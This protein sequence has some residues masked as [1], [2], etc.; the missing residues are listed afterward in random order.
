MAKR[1]LFR[2]ETV[3]KVRKQR[4]DACKRA[5]AERLRRISA[6][7]AEIGSLRTQINT[8]IGAFR[9]AHA[10][11]R[12]DMT[13][14]ARH[15]HWLIHLHQGVLMAQAG[16]HELRQKL[17]EDRKVLTEARKQTRVLEKLKE[18][19]LERHRQA[20][21]RAEAVEND[22]IGNTLYAR[23]MMASSA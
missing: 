16:L 22:E 14:I 15:R 12:L 6:V 18:R 5:V 8:E 23:Q 11:G 10:V 1:F 21:N 19:Q 17:V 2:L 3:L 13:Q 4:E 7:Q 20:L 9:E